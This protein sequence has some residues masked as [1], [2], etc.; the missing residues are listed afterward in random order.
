MIDCWG[1]YEIAV[2]ETA[3]AR[4]GLNGWREIGREIGTKTAGECEVGLFDFSSIFLGIRLDVHGRGVVVVVA[5]YMHK[6][7]KLCICVLASVYE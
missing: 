5:S 4:Y 6:V 7:I 2:F 3:L 1:P